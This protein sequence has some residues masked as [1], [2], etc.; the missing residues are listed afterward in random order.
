MRRYQTTSRQIFIVNHHNRIKAHLVALCLA[1]LVL[2]SNTLAFSTPFSLFKSFRPSQHSALK[3]SEDTQQTQ[4]T[5]FGHIPP[6]TIEEIKTYADI[7]TV[8]ESYNLPFFSRSSDGRA[9]CVCPFHND[10]NP[11]LNIDNS[12]GIYKC[13]S[14]GAGGDVF[15][16]VREYDF[17]SN[18]QKGAKMNYPA[19][20]QK[21]AKEF[22]G[23]SLA[24]KIESTLSFGNYNRTMSPEKRQKFE[25]RRKEKERILLANSAA[26]DFY[27]KALIT[28]PAAGI[29]RAHL[30][31]RGTTPALVRTF[32]L[33]FAPEAY[34]NKSGKG[35]ADAW[36]KGSLVERLQEL[37]F[38]PQE[39]LDAGLVTITSKARSRL[40]MSSTGT[41]LGNNFDEDVVSSVMVESEMRNQT[42]AENTADA[43]GS[44]LEYNDLMDRFR[45]RL[46]VPIF[47][48]SGR[49]VVGFGGRHLEAPKSGEPNGAA[50]KNQQSYQAAKYLNSPETPVFEK[51]NILFGLHSASAA[52]DDATKPR[53][54]EQ[55]NTNPDG[56]TFQSTTPTIVIV[57]GYFD[58]ITLYGAGV[59]EVVASMGTALTTSQLN[60][61]VSA[62]GGRGRIILCLDSDEAGLNAVER[63]CTGSSIWD[64]LENN[65][66]DVNVASL[67]FGIKDPAEFIEA[68]GGVGKASS[69]ESFRADVLEE[70]VPWN[71]WYISRLI[72][73]FDPDDSTSFSTICESVA[74]FLSTHP[75]AADRTR[76]AYEAAGKLAAYITKGQGGS[77]E[78][79]LRIQLESDLLGMASRK[80]SAREAL[81]RRVEAADGEGGSKGK[82][83]R[84]SSGEATTQDKPLTSSLG[85]KLAQSGDGTKSR[86]IKVSQ[87]RPVKKSQPSNSRPQP[88]PRQDDTFQRRGNT[89]DRGYNREKQAPPLTRHFNGF[90]FSDTDAA[91]LGLTNAKV[92]LIAVLLALSLFSRS[93]TIYLFILRRGRIFF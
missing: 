68:K 9:K 73:R 20:I 7:V 15:N 46:M 5:G 48:V 43:P 33:G 51:K 87:P 70:A 72:S 16:F 10:R 75:N 47:D 21:V 53:N 29:A 12:K 2:A 84:L 39:I 6:E 35:G 67:P 57:E 40:Q 4:Q 90:Q 36:G 69:G 32:A 28:N 30:H 1:I 77:S 83:A 56:L 3:A 50:D 44:Q 76:R 82:L 26:A 78:G 60:M 63:V 85:R 17:I 54:A 74:T 27:A 59:K 58:A 80:A 25:E 91:W 79:P 24:Q 65:G 62:L 13:F 93:Q 41:S 81:A 45:S 92:R 23:G 71:D 14:C 55:A 86:P 42:K 88:Y 38:T 61:A 52:I 37:N 34:F 89:F 18:N 11:S 22:C 8:I 49:N 31:Q 64:F 66:V 19:A